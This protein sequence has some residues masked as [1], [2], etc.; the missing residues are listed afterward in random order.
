[1]LCDAAAGP[2]NIT[3]PDAYQVPEGTQFTVMKIAQVMP[4]DI[5]DITITPVGS[6]LFQ[7]Y[8]TP[9]SFFSLR[10][11]LLSVTFIRA[12]TYLG[13][14]SWRIIGVGP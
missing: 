1:V 7:G 8:A 11:G 2:I 13:V 4:V 5:N 10:A 6:D 9:F 3:L 14:T 12:S